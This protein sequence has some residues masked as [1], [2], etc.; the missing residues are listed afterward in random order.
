MPYARPVAFEELK[1]RQAA[2]WGSAPFERIAVTLAD[3]HEAIVEVTAPA[4]GERLLDVGCG[5]GELA[6][7]ASHTGAE[8]TGADIAPELVET[9]RRQASERGLSITFDVADVENLP[10]GAA[11]FDIV[12]STVGAIFAPDHRRVAG[13]LA[14]VCKPGGRLA[15]TAWTADGEVDEF[16][17]IIGSYAPPPAEGAGNPMSWGDTG[18]ATEML[19]ETFDLRFEHRNTPW[20]M[21]SPE[22]AWNEMA[23]AFGPI[24]TLLRNLP[25]ERAESFRRELIGYFET[26]DGGSGFVLDRRYVVISGTRL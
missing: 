6:F 22:A 3:M 24:A 25:P 2:M 16:F 26:T 7:R 15:L 8:V 5:T 13:E 9:A 17:R 23:E 12:T 11:S 1:Q 14:R 10:Y 21:E 4:A 18:Y 19:G 20:R